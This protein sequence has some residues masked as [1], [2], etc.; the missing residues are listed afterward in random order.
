MIRH[1]YVATGTNDTGKQV[2][3]DRWNE[4]HVVD[5]EINFPLIPTPAAPAVDT[6]NIFATKIG[7]RMLLAQEGP[8]G[9]DTSFQPHLG[10]NKVAA[11]IPPGGATTVPGLFGMAALTATGTATMR[12]AA[13]LLP[14][15]SLLK[16]ST[17]G[18]AP[19]AR[20]AAS[21]AFS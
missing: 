8:S 17:T 9:L 20:A 18:E 15:S 19:T 10:G 7:G 6:L 1:S 13:R 4:G 2:S 5:A 11:W 3:K 16:N 14:S 12:V 21:T